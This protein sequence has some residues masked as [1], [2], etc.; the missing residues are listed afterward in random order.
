MHRVLALAA[1]LTAALLIPAASAHHGFTAHFDPDQIIR[2]DGTVTQFDFIN[3]HGFLHIDA[4]D[5]DGNAVSYVCDLQARTQLAR[6]GVD[7][8]LFTV[9]EHIVVEGFPARRDPY[10]CD[11]GTGYFDDGSTF[12]MRSSDVGQTQFA[13][14]EIAEAARGGY[15]GVFG[16]WIRPTI[17]GARGG[18]GMGSGTD[19]ITETGLAALAE[20]DPIEDN[21]VNSCEPA[22]PI[23]TWGA[24]GLATSIRQVNSEIIIYHESMDVTRRI[25]LTMDEHPADMVPSDMGHSIGRLEGGNLIIDTAG[26]SEGVIVGTTLNSDRMTMQERLSVDAQTGDLIVTWV[27]DEPVYYA[28]PI[29]GSQ[30]LQSTADTIIRYECIPNSYEQH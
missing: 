15:R 30:T 9:G 8:T 25:Q 23:R 16:N 4:I 1:S 6:R 10:G 14:N 17:Y 22:S 2:I 3:P 7:E 29:T 24:P 27:I 13:Q 19:S 21:P 12:T 11:F 20:Y 5:D 26:F 18:M 28:E